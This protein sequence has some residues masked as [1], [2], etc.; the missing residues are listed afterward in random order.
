MDQATLMWIFL[1]IAAWSGRE[2]LHSW[3][4]LFTDLSPREYLAWYSIV[5]FTRLGF[6]LMSVLWS[7]Q[8][9]DP[10]GIANWSVT[11]VDWSERK[12]HPKSYRAQDITYELLKNITVWSSLL[13]SCILLCYVAAFRKYFKITSTFLMRLEWLYL[14]AV[15]WP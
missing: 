12:W 14:F 1:I 3:W 10:L 4:T 13:S 9:A 8:L 5:N 15:N 7:L 2:K 6:V 11:H